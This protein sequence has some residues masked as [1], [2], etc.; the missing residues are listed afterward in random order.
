M[1]EIEIKYNI[2]FLKKL[3]NIVIILNRIFFNIINIL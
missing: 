2:C 3:F 1:L